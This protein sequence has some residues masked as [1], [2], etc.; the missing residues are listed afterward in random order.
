[1]FSN[2]DWDL[3]RDSL[4]VLD[5]AK[6]TGSTPGDGKDVDGEARG[7]V[8]GTLQLLD[9]L[10]DIC[11]GERPGWMEE[12]LCTRHDTIRRFERCEEETRQLQL[13]MASKPSAVQGVQESGSGRGR[14]Q[15]EC[16]VYSMRYNP[17]APSKQRFCPYILRQTKEYRP[18]CD[19][20]L[21]PGG[22]LPKF[23]V[24][25]AGLDQSHDLF[26]GRRAF[27]SYHKWIECDARHRHK[28]TEKVENGVKIQAT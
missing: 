2:I 14:C 4:L 21:L 22:L 5:D 20:P 3:L 7:C 8:D 26:R 6:P 1:M 9:G 17:R 28:R 24:G 11:E 16:C 27:A 13:R 19:S 25:D 18:S 23:D 15:R 10:Y 12:A